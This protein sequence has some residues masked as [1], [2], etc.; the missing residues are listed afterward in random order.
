MLIADCGTL[1]SSAVSPAQWVH[2]SPQH[3][4]VMS[5]H[6]R[7]PLT[8]N[9]GNL[10]L[11]IKWCKRAEVG[12]LKESWFVDRTWL[13]DTPMLVRG[14]GPVCLIYTNHLEKEQRKGRFCWRTRSK[15]FGRSLLMSGEEEPMSWWRWMKDPHWKKWVKTW[16]TMITSRRAAPLPHKSWQYSYSERD[17]HTHTRP[18]I[19]LS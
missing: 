11:G 15:L 9:V 7:P 19:Q 12:G 13:A 14:V 10:Y 16:S 1:S 2:T 17:T 5:T 8:G 18:D 3:S 6:T 4:A